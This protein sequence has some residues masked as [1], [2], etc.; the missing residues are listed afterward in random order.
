MG[1]LLPAVDIESY[2][3]PIGHLER[4]FVYPVKSMD[5]VWLSG[6]GFDAHGA[7]GD[8]RV[9]FRFVGSQSRNARAYVTSRDRGVFDLRQFTPYFAPTG[10]EEKFG[11]RVLVPG[12]DKGEVVDLA[13]EDPQL[14]QEL[15]RRTG[16]KV[17]LVASKRGVFD[18]L[19]V[20]IVDRRSLALLN[21][22]LGYE[23]SPRVFKSTLV[24]DTRRGF[25]LE[26]YIED[27][28]Q[29][30]ILELGQG[31]LAPR[32]S[33][34]GPT[35]RCVVVNQVPPGERD[36]FREAKQVDRSVQPV[37]RALRKIAEFGNS[38]DAE[39]IN[40][41]VYAQVLKPGFAP[42]GATVYGARLK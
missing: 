4:A 13:V 35:A 42:V 1:E 15:E 28:W 39:T 23:V 25:L 40:F 34:V 8:R 21:Q 11:I 41:G 20:H 38:D 37:L 10:G 6:V 19:G 5:D 2:F 7:V 14:I 32:L 12:N 16:K 9:G 3:Q 27:N 29:G 18:N 26:K 24:I 17:E 36:V 31:E 22:R 30:L 33:I